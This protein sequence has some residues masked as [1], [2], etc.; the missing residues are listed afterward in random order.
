MSRFFLGLWLLLVTAV[1]S[2]AVTTLDFLLTDARLGIGQATNRIVYVQ[3]MSLPSTTQNSVVLGTRLTFIT[4]TNGEFFMTNAFGP[5]L[6]DVTVQAP[7]SRQSFTILVTSTN[8]GTIYAAD[9]LVASS[10]ATFPAGTVAWSASVSDGRYSRTSNNLASYAT[11]SYTTNLVGTLSNSLGSAAFSNATVF[12]PTTNPSNFISSADLSTYATKANLATQGTVQTNDTISR[13]AIQGAIITNIVS[14]NGTNTTNY[15]IS[16]AL[17]ATNFTKLVGTSLTNY[18]LSTSNALQAAFGASGNYQPT[19]INLTNW[20]TISTNWLV[21]SN[22]FITFT[23]TFGTAAFTPL[24]AYQPTS[25]VLT[26][27]VSFGTNQ[28]YPR[29]NPSGYVSAATVAATYYPLSNPSSYVTA[30]VTNGL[31]P[32]NNP[33]GFVTASVTNGL[34][35]SNLV[36]VMTNTLYGA[37]QP[38]NNVLTLLAAFGTN[39]WYPRANPAG[40]VDST[41]T[42]GLATT[43]Y[44]NLVSNAIVSGTGFQPASVNL[45]NWSA[46]ATNGYMATNA[47][48]AGFQV[49]GNGTGTNAFIGS[50]N[51]T[52]YGLTVR[53]NAFNA[54]P[55][56]SYGNAIFYGFPSGLTAAAT[57]TNTLGGPGIIVANG[58]NIRAGASSQLLLTDNQLIHQLV[59]QDSRLFVA[60]PTVTDFNQFYVANAS[61]GLERASLASV[62]SAVGASYQP[63]S[64]NLTNW[65]T[66]STNWLVNSN[67]FITFTN[68]LKTAAFQPVA[69][70]QPASSTLTNWSLHGTNEYYPTTANLQAGSTALTNFSLLGTNAFIPTGAGLSKGQHPV[71]NGTAWTY[72]SIPAGV[73]VLTY[74]TT[75][76]SGQQWV[77]QVDPQNLGVGSSLSTAVLYRDGVW[78]VPAASTNGTNVAIYS[79]SQFTTNVNAQIAIK[80][81]ASVTNLQA[82][83]TTA[84]NSVTASGIVSG[85]VDTVALTASSTANIGDITAIS[86]SIDDLTVTSDAVITGSVSASDITISS[87]ADLGD[88]NAISL[89]VDSF[90]LTESPTAGYVLTSDASGNGSWQLS[91][92]AQTPWA[93]DINANTNSLTNLYSLQYHAEP[94]GVL[95]SRDII[96]MSDGITLMTY[97]DTGPSN[98]VIYL[99]DGTFMDA[100]ALRINNS[101]GN[102]RVTMVFGEGDD[103]DRRTWRWHDQFIETGT[104]FQSAEEAPRI[105]QHDGYGNAAIPRQMKITTN[106][107]TAPT[108]SA[109]STNLTQLSV[110]GRAGDVFQFEYHIYVQQFADYGCEVFL[111]STN[112]PTFV[113]Y[114][115]GYSSSDS[116][117]GSKFFTTLTQAIGGPDT[118]T[119]MDFCIK[120]TVKFSGTDMMT[121]KVRV[122]NDGTAPII[123]QGSSL[124]AVKNFQAPSVYSPT[125]YVAP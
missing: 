87:T 65:A 56:T 74:N 33:S 124:Q 73:S 63:A 111:V 37:T 11:I 27:L 28:W 102:P 20:S 62:I 18:V 64:L 79:P 97:R 93:S 103:T 59:F 115:I 32:S 43:A 69:A 108:T 123:R 38:T 51:G 70:F 39:Q 4:D 3:P 23:N 61:N 76:A 31:Y 90:R 60:T 15:I 34:I 57:F 83:G 91:G 35:A 36:V 68:T 98:H 8:L 48:L 5:C 67:T 19:S 121:P 53:S 14:V 66:I 80:S 22:A 77:S 12:Y 52:G 10:T 47:A 16:N 49:V 40:Y 46:Q 41:V 101:G 55:I 125:A 72:Q 82:A 99:G 109:S 94:E 114:T 2:S 122:H 119:Y 95:N 7:P 75:T 54:P 50:T 117:V 106:S 9:C 105:F 26:D 120:G 107:V 116:D 45:T 86:A 104:A 6:Y 110:I 58:A 84:M 92:G 113:N 78:R 44:V 118:D 71:W 25:Q 13:L 85:S 17:L 1:S 112:S 100:I 29:A 30:A 96:K 88:V 21:N 89:A 42:N 81:G 24:T